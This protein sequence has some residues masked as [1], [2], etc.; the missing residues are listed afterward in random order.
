MDEP[1]PKELFLQSLSRCTAAENFIP[2]FYDRFLNSSDDV[3]EKSQHTDFERQNRMLLRSLK[4][5]AAAT[6]GD[7]EG[8]R[9]LRERAETH[10]RY[11]LNI[12]PKFY[13]LWRS[14]IIDTASETDA[15]WN[16]ATNNA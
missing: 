7:P 2:S 5:A 3:R 4:L 8:L 9:E 1:T 13:Y 16:D 11:H 10:D 14:A 6:S 15:L 12:E